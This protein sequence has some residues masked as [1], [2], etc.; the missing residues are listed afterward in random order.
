MIPNVL[1]EDY[2]NT[3]FIDRNNASLLIPI[4]V[5][6]QGVLEQVEITDKH[7]QHVLVA[8]HA[9]SGKSNYLHTVLTSLLLNYSAEQLNIWLSDSG[10]YEFNRFAK[11]APAQ[12]KQ[13]NT[14][15]EPTSYIAFVDALEE[16]INKRIQCLAKMGRTSYYSCVTESENCPFPRL[17]VVLD[18][19]DHV[20]RDLSKINRD[21]VEKFDNAVR[22][23]SACGITFLVST[24]E[25]LFLAQQINRRFFESFGIRIAT[26]QSLDSYSILFD[27]SAAR[28]VQDFKLGE[29][30]VNTQGVHKVK[31]LYLADSIE[32]DIIK[33]VYSKST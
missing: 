26:K 19:F 14:S 7:W 22:Y 11:H 28:L 4:G 13:I 2:I 17:M 15:S 8:G 23:A 32:D 29:A 25:A 18:C 24:Q 12:I 10:M 21:Y 33:T 1:F 27:N 9:G 5:N 20:I 30:I 16:E 31:L 6:Q 3:T